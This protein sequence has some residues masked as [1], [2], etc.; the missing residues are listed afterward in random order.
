LPAALPVVIV[1]ATLDIANVVLV[2][3]L[4]SFL[5]LGA[6]APAPEL[7]AMTARSLETLVDFWWPPILPAIAIFLMAFSAN[8][9]GDW[10][11]RRFEFS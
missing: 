4:F 9:V 10:L 6:P 8:L 11:R 3:S 1:T 5:G 7:G 2:L